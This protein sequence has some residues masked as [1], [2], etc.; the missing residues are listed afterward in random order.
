MERIEISGFTLRR[1][2]RRAPRAP[3]GVAAASRFLP[4]AH[5]AR[6]ASPGASSSSRRCSSATCRSGACASRP[7]ALR[8]F[9]TMVAHYHGQ[10][11]NAAE[12]ARA[13]GVNRSTV[14]PLPRPADRRPHGP[15]AA[16]LA[17]QPRQA[18]GQV[19]RRSTCA[20]AV[21]CTSCSGIDEREGPA[22]AI[23]SSAPRGRASSSSRCSRASPTTRPASGPRTRAPRSTCSCAAASRLLGVECKRADAPRLTPSIRIA[24]EDLGLERVAVVYPGAKRYALGERVEA[25]P[26]TTLAE[27]GRLFGEKAES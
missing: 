14:P 27:P 15:P 5:R 12:P 10:T 11:W 22:H 24:L 1:A 9:W 13:L 23:P 26:L 21:C 25:V 18:P 20:T 4:G 16:A 3:S 19:A 2:G 8:R 17:R 6:T 7:A